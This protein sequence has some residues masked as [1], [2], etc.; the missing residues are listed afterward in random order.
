MQWR[1]FSVCNLG[2]NEVEKIDSEEILLNADR[3]MLASIRG[4]DNICKYLFDQTVR[5]IA[6]KQK[7][8]NLGIRLL[9][10]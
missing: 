10:L 6:F 7:R 3:K 9:L 1:K 5:C 8:D 2:K 4:D